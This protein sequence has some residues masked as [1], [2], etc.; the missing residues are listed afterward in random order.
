MYYHNAL[1]N[2]YP[3]SSNDTYKCSS[4]NTGTRGLRANC[5]AH[6]IRTAV[7]RELLLDAIKTVSGYARTNEAEF[8]RRVHEASELQQEAAAKASRKQLAKSQK[9][10]A[11]LDEVIS[12][13]FEQNATGKITEGRFEIL[14]AGYEKE[15]A[16]LADAS[17]KLQFEL[18]SFDA[19]SVRADRFIEIVKRYTDFSELTT[20][21]IHEFI[22]KVIIHEGDRSSGERV[23]KVDVYLNF[24]GKFDVPL[25][26]PEPTP[27]EI[28]AAE[29]LK[30][31]RERK[32]INGQR[33]MEKRKRELAQV[34][35]GG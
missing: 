4:C 2:S 22:D 15:Q 9:R 28:A 25:P 11:E 17:A 19:D 27:E 10:H 29:K 13:L 21:M 31:Q 18:D 30:K 34:Q 14:L 5:T 3:A 33:F 32:R 16:E 24:I 7:V 1:G 6:F 20:P 35:Q 8:V 26:Q 12:K 23:Q